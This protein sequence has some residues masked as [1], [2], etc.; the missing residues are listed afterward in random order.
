MTDQYQSQGFKEK[1]RGSVWSPERTWTAWV[2]WHGAPGPPRS[3]GRSVFG[4]AAHCSWPAK[5]IHELKTECDCLYGWIKK[6]S[7]TQKSQKK[8]MNPTDIGRNA[9]EEEEEN[10][11]NT[12][13]SNI[14]VTLWS[15]VPRSWLPCHAS[16]QTLRHLS[17]NCHLTVI[18]LPRKPPLAQTLTQAVEFVCLFVG[19]LLNVATTCKCTG[20]TS[21]STDPI[22]SRAWQGSHLN[23]N[24]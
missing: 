12:T 9:E 5:H 20:P 16:H 2:C 1:K 24:F 23:A 8:I 10:L 18:F 21:P 13:H 7:H 22:M 4:L 14:Q 6:W 15:W 19:C 3:S 11:P 17:F